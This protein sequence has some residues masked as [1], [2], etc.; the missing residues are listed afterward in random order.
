MRERQP[1]RTNK[2]NFNELSADAC[3]RTVDL[4]GSEWCYR[5]QMPEHRILRERFSQ[6]A[7][8][9]RGDAGLLVDQRRPQ[10]RL[11]L[12]QGKQRS[13]AAKGDG[14]DQ[15]DRL[16]RA[17]SIHWLKFAYMTK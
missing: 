17:I 12:D 7:R 11:G 4:S 9:S 6:F 8:T 10:I 3:F 1:G 5:E 14:S 13:F 2:G 15:N 16:R